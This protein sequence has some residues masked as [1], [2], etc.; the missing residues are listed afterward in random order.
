MENKKDNM[1]VKI[2]LSIGLCWLICAIVLTTVYPK[3]LFF[4]LFLGLGIFFTVYSLKKIQI[5]L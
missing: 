5:L 3:N 1:D 4:T 2:S